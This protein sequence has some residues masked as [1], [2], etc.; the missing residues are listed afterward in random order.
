MFRGELIPPQHIPT[1]IYPQH[2]PTMWVGLAGLGYELVSVAERHICGGK[3]WF[4]RGTRIG[5]EGQVW[6][7]LSLS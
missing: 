5:E 2:V 7:E 3:L 6:R 1:L 4:R